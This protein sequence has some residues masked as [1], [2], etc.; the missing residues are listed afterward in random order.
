MSKYPIV[1]VEIPAPDPDAAGKF[2]GDMFGWEIEKYDEFDY[3]VFSPEEGPG[4]GFPAT[5]EVM[6][7]DR[8][9]VYVGSED[10]E[11]DLKKIEGLGGKTVMAKTEIPGTGWFAIFT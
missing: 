2:Y 10:I 4:G 7:V 1:H 5:D 9:M 8:L 6:K 11:A 3:V